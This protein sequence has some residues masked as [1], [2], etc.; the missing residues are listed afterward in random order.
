MP[1]TIATTTNIIIINKSASLIIPQLPA[2]ET[3]KITRM[4]NVTVMTITKIIYT[5]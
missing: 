4:T 5:K 3:G 1:H 2:E